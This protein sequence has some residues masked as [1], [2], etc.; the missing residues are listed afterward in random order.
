MSTTVEHPHET[1]DV[2]HELANGRYTVSAPNA[3]AETAIPGT[4][5]VS[6]TR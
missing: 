4:P 2:S 1:Y 6:I 3:L 5:A